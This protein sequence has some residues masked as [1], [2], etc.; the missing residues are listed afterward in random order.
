MQPRRERAVANHSPRAHPVPAL[1]GPDSVILPVSF[2][3]HSSAGKMS[4]HSRHSF[5]DERYQE[6]TREYITLIKAF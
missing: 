2:S 6:N 1:G 3:P 4:L 5:K